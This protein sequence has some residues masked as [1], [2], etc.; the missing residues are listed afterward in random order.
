MRNTNSG[1]NN[2]LITGGTS[3]LGLELGR[4]FLDKGY[5]VVATGRQLVN[6]PGYEDRFKLFRVDFS[7]MEQVAVSIKK[8]CETYDFN[9]VINN[10][11]ILSP[12]DYTP[13][14]NGYEYT[15]QVN[16]LSHLIVNEII[17]RKS[18]STFPLIIAAVTS[19]V[20]RLAGTAFNIQ[21]ESVYYNTLK[22]Y[23]SSKLY[24][25]IMC[26][27]LPVRFPELDLQ[28]FS[29]D[30][31]TFSSGIYRMQRKWFRG[32]YRFAAPFMRSP[33]KVAR[34]LT[35][36][37]INEKVENGKI[38]DL[39]KRCRPVPLI[40]QK[41]KDAFRERCYEIIEPFLSS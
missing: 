10:A 6:M 23:T 14:I 4:L 1:K 34:V 7:N 21:S 39:K 17:L 25:T 41:E 9:F 37:L 26:E 35:D 38:Y 40:G 18:K 32:M 15:F 20:Y 29:F 13:T 27:F 22:A 8:I 3:G 33:E 12:P 11:G 36:I 5:N 24:L 16:Y 19:P 2:V 28:C 30:P 31:G